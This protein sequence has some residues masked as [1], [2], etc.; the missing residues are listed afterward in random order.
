MQA[1][2]RID[3]KVVWHE[4]ANTLKFLLLLLLFGFLWLFA[5][6]EICWRRGCWANIDRLLFHDGLGEGFFVLKCGALLGWGW[7]L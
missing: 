1:H 3:G 2:Y 4:V 5:R 7:R 6:L